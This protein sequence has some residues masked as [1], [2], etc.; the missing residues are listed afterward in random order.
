MLFGEKERFCAISPF[1]AYCY[2][3]PEAEDMKYP[4]RQMVQPVWTV[5]I[6]RVY[7]LIEFANSPLSYFIFIGRGL[8]SNGSPHRDGTQP[9]L[10]PSTHF[11]SGRTLHCKRIQTFALRSERPTCPLCWSY[12]ERGQGWKG[13]RDQLELPCKFNNEEALKKCTRKKSNLA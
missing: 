10:A 4:G 1:L 11:Q 6:V 13:P 2:S 12:C 5:V 7:Q 9:S 8:M 3:G